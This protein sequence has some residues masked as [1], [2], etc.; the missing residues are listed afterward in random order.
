MAKI[1]MIHM[2]KISLITIINATTGFYIKHKINS[3]NTKNLILKNWNR[4]QWKKQEWFIMT[5]S[6]YWLRLVDSTVQFQVFSPFFLCI[7]WGNVL[8]KIFYLIFIEIIKIL[9]IKM[10]LKL[11]WNMHFLLKTFMKWR[12]KYNFW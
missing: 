8:K 4:H 11:R 5:L 7:L 2:N 6:N 10:M 9:K 12:I 3:Q 1:N